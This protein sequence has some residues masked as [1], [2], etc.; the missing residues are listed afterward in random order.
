[1]TE[2]QDEPAWNKR[3]PSGVYKYV[4]ALQ[5]GAPEHA[6]NDS[7]GFSVGSYAKLARVQN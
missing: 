2:Q 7:G 3:K 4:G 6:L 1:M 5:K